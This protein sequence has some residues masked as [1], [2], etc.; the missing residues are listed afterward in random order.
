MWPQRAELRRA[1]T[2]LI[3][4]RNRLE[5][6]LNERDESAGELERLRTEVETL[7]GA[8]DGAIRS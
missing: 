7:R 6:M 4:A 5:S 8:A 2:E 3:T 1:N